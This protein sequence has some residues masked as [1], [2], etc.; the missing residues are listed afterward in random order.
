MLG[1]DD[2]FVRLGECNNYF[3]HLLIRVHVVYFFL[4]FCEK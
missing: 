2:L 3:I 4:F 1:E